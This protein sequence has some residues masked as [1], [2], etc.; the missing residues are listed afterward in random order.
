MEKI[1]FDSGIQE[2]PLGE[3]VLRFNPTDP[4]LYAR[5]FQVAEDFK[6]PEVEEDADPVAALTQLDKHMKQQLNEIF[7]LGNDFDAILGG[8]SL[9]AVADNGQRVLDNL[10]AA[11]TPVLAEGAQKCADALA[12]SAVAQAQKRRDALA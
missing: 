6:V 2:M 9:L 3:G 5:F 4:N 1:V 12:A 7:G 10:L 8:V 11:L